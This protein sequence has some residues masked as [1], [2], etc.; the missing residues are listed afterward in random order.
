MILVSVKC[1]DDPSTRGMAFA[2]DWTE[3][4]WVIDQAFGDPE[5][6]LIAPHHNYGALCVKADLIDEG[7]GPFWEP[8]YSSLQSDGAQYEAYCLTPVSDE[9]FVE[10]DWDYVRTHNRPPASVIKLFEPQICGTSLYE[11]TVRQRTEAKER[12]NGISK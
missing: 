11:N 8:D 2:R 7:D 4:Y 12:K 5:C 3:L 10:M 6:F 1:E 9:D